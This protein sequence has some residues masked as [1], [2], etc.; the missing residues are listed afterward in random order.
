MLADNG[1]CNSRPL[2]NT[3]FWPCFKN[4]Y[5]LVPNTFQH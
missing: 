1:N 3:V 4:S 5:Q 2:P